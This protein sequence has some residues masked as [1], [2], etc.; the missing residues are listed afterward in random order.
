M[1]KILLLEDDPVTS[2]EIN[3]LFSE[4]CQLHIT[5]SANIALHLVDLNKYNLVMIDINLQPDGS[6]L[7]TVHTIKNMSSYNSFPI[8][9]FTLNIS[10]VNKEY[11]ISRGYTHLI[12]GSFNIR[13]FA[14]QIKFI[15]SSHLDT[16]RNSFLPSES[17]P[18]PKLMVHN[19]K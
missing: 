16:N 1:Y 8:V 2:S 10:K 12:S 17:L 18:V 11:L 13:N 3:K 15:I 5:R 4:F 6:A 19:G 9:G 14:Q 7:N